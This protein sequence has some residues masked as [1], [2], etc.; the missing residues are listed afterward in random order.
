[1]RIRIGDFVMGING[2]RTEH[3]LMGK[4]M[5]GKIARTVGVVNTIPNMQQQ[6]LFADFDIS[7]LPNV[8]HDIRDWK[9]AF[10]MGD[11]FLFQ[12]GD[13]GDKHYFIISPCQYEPQ[14]IRRILAYANYVDDK[15]VSTYIRYHDNTIRIIPKVKGKKE[16]RPIKFL[17]FIKGNTNRTIVRGMMEL[18]IPLYPNIKDYKVSDIKNGIHLDKTSKDDLTMRE[19]ETIRW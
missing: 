1:M 12:S 14:E 7:S 16:F 19:Y 4:F 15:F 13:L 17:M 11:I 2:N 6:M 18:L 5:I 8:M 9:D 10:N 3:A